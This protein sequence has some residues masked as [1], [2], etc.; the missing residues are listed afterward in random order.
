MEISKN[1]G[2]IMTIKLYDKDPYQISFEANVVS[3]AKYGEK[4]DVVLD[5][6]LFFPEEGGQ[7]CDKG[8]IHDIDVLDV[9]IK[10]HVIHHYLSA[11]VDGKVNGTIDFDYRYSNMQNHSGE[12]VLSGIVHSLYGLNNVGFHLG[13]HEIT[14][15]YDGF[16]SKKQLN[17]IENKVNQ[18]ILEHKSIKCYYPRDLQHL[19]YRSKKEIEGDIRIVE[20]E[21]VDM[22]ACCAPHVRS[23]SEIGLFKIIKA[24]KYKKGMRIYFLCGKRAIADYQVKHDEVIRISNILSSPAY[25]VSHNVQRI[26]DEN[27]HLKQTIFMLKKQMIERTCQ[28][29]KQADNYIEFVEDMDPSLQQYYLNQLFIKS[30]NMAAVFVGKDNDY[31]FMIAATDDARIYISLLKEKHIVKGGGKKDIVQGTV[32][33]SQKEILNILKNKM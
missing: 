26:L 14:T 16:L 2:E 19:E 25:L 13:D 15:D 5:Q 8:T 27:N 28:S 12:H 7:N 6:T 30:K 1:R 29:L 22:C 33:A 23:T 31:R 9:Q 10:D 3:C 32:V 11:P 18:V 17:D 24:I 21:D 4:Y 20:I